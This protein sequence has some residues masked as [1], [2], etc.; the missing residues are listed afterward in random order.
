MSQD[1]ENQNMNSE[2]SEKIISKENE[3]IPKKAN[4]KKKYLKK[5]S[6]RQMSDAQIKVIPLLKPPSRC[7]KFGKSQN[8]KKKNNEKT[9]VWDNKT[10]EKQ[11]LDRKLHPRIKID[12]NKALY[13]NG[14]DEDLYQEGINKVNGI[15]PTKEI[16]NNV[17]ETLNKMDKN[18]YNNKANKLKK[19]VYD[20]E[21]LK[22]Y[23]ENIM[24]CDD[25]S[26]ERIICLQNTLINKFHKELRTLSKE[27]F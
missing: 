16:I 20:N 10:I 19:N 4:R 14:D 26:G 5:T 9:I 3:S 25:L 15:K 2:N 27:K 17:I 8:L 7:R 21:A 6:K 23:H 11:Y 22:F 12:E 1:K 13:P 18:E 24:K